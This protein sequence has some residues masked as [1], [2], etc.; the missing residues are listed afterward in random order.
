MQALRG[1][2]GSFGIV[3]SI[4]VRTFTPPPSAIVFE[5]QW[6][7]NVPDLSK[8]LAAWQT[9]V[10]TDIP[11][12]FGGE[13]NLRQGSTSG[14][15]SFAILGG[16]YGAAN[17]LN[18]TIAPLL[19]AMPRRPENTKLTPG[20]YIDSVTYLAGGSLDTH[21]APDI[22]DNFYA[23]SLMTPM[24]TPMSQAAL[25]AFA[26]Y[27]INQG[28]VSNTVRTSNL[29][30][31]APILHRLCSTELV[32]TGRVVWRSEFCHKRCQPRRDFLRAQKLDVHDTVLRFSSKHQLDVPEVRVHLHGWCV[33]LLR[34]P[35]DVDRDARCSGAV[36]SIVSNSPSNWDYR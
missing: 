4:E 25:T 2:A 26:S 28:P 7:F 29:L 33:A 17:K 36:N 16:W 27:I 15:V 31:T 6:D 24:S 19:A 3:T 13:I 32:Y 30:S 12:E 8:G 21:T 14:T 1:S 11:A 35:T 34:S 23:K 9:F 5:Y 22:H 10:Q 18:A 20:T